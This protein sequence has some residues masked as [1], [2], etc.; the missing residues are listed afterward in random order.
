MTGSTEIN[1]TFSEARRPPQ[2][3]SIIKRQSWR[4]LPR[5]QAFASSSEMYLQTSVVA[6][7]VCLHQPYLIKHHESD[8]ACSTTASVVKSASDRC[9]MQPGTNTSDN[10]SPAQPSTSARQFVGAGQKNGG[11][12][13][14][15]HTPPPRAQ[16]RSGGTTWLLPPLGCCIAV[17]IASAW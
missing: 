1:S 12:R 11:G 2:D 5:S 13:V 9:G 3:N 10:G 6:I 15:R 4:A 17:T 16:S 14:T 7:S 8:G